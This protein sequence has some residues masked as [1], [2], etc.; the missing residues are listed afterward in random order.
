MN[1][2]IEKLLSEH[3]SDMGELIGRIFNENE[4]R[5]ITESACQAQRNA[6][7]RVYDEE[8][9]ESSDYFGDYIVSAEI[10]EADYE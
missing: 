7:K 9:A 5:Q 10:T 8:L 2:F 4:V 1:E 6:C 3:G